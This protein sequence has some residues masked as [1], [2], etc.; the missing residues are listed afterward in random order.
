[1]SILFVNN[2]YLKW[3]LRLKWRHCNH[4]QSHFVNLL[5][6]V[7]QFVGR[8]LP[9]RAHFQWK[10]SHIF[11]RVATVCGISLIK[12]N[13]KQTNKKWNTAGVFKL[14][15]NTKEIMWPKQSIHKYWLLFL[16]KSHI[17]VPCRTLSNLIVYYCGFCMFLSCW[18][19]FKILQNFQHTKTKTYS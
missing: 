14:S 19:G 6:S 9:I 1:M 10:L 3:F 17:I 13:N 11:V 15:Y 7:F 2:I 5:L 12:N 18:R 4:N 8:I 16:I